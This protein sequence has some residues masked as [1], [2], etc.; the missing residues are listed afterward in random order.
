MIEFFNSL[1]NWSDLG[2]LA[3]R[4]ALGAIFLVHGTSKLKM[5]KMK[6]S[7]QMSAGMLN[8]MRFL[9]V[10][11]TLGALSMASGVLAQPA[12]AGLALVMLGAIYFKISKWHTGFTAT[13]KVGWEFDL[14]LLASALAIVFIGPGIYSI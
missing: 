12:A 4:I 6:P 10:A 13:D 9:S 11:E 14:I 8:T 3:L 7:G 1:H 2:L 5:W